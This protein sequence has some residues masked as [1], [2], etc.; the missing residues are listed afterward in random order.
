[1]EQINEMPSLDTVI[2]KTKVEEN[3]NIT[4][5]TREVKYGFYKDYSIQMEEN[6]NLEH[7]FESQF[8]ENQDLIFF[9]DTWKQEISSQ[10][11]QQNE[12]VFCHME[13]SNIHIYVPTK[14]TYLTHKAVA[15]V[16]GIS[17]ENVFIH[18]TK[19]SGVYPTGL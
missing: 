18:K 5:A 7:P 16:L 3:P 2:D 10:N 13:S 15:E 8:F 14:W 12:G 6:K 11:W 19:T 4:I 17:I 1:M 9:D